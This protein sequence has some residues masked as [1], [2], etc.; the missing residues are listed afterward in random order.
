M[1]A[2]K[3]KLSFLTPY[4]LICLPLFNLLQQTE[5]ASLVT[6]M[7]S[8][9]LACYA[10]SLH[11]VLAPF[12]E[13]APHLRTRRQVHACKVWCSDLCSK[14]WQ[15]ERAGQVHRTPLC[16]L[17]CYAAGCTEVLGLTWPDVLVIPQTENSIPV[18]ALFYK[19]E[20]F[21]LVTYNILKI[22]L[23]SKARDIQ[24]SWSTKECLRS[25]TI[26]VEPLCAP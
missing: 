11:S 5:R 18:Y 14:L 6:T 24:W 10:S 23:W 13:L 21:W 9:K 3:R 1:I 20:L 4:V 26:W 2:E 22:R 7:P 16:N 12:V 15:T 8:C 19:V 25:S 17:N